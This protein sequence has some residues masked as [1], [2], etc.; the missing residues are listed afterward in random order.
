MPGVVAEPTVGTMPRAAASKLSASV[1]LPRFAQQSVDRAYDESTRL[2]LADAYQR[3]I[4]LK[5]RPPLEKLL[6]EKDQFLKDAEF[7][8]ESKLYTD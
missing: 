7:P 6:V 4:G 2:A 5:E 3:A 1:S 8:D